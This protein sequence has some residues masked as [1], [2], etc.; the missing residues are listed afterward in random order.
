[1]HFLTTTLPRPIANFMTATGSHPT[2]QWS[3]EAE[4]KHGRVAMVALASLVT[5]QSA[6][7]DEPVRW[8]SQQPTDTQLVFFS[9]AAALES[10]S[11][12][13]LAGFARLRP[14]VEAG[15]FWPLGP[16]S[17]GVN[18]AEDWAGRAAMLVTFAWMVNTVAPDF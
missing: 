3:V 2:P 17:K 8:L 7:I 5:L 16:G 4:K 9:Q 18:A 10:L 6:G 15:R 12:R 1:M 14:E 11:L 13:R